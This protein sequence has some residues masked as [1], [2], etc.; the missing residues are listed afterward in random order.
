[1][2]G[3]RLLIACGVVIGLAAC[4]RERPAPEMTPLVGVGGNVYCVSDADELA[5]K[6]KANT[7]PMAT[8]ILIHHYNNCKPDKNR[9][10][11]LLK[12]Q[13]DRGD[14]VMM[15]SLEAFNARIEAGR[16]KTGKAK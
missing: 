5:L 12:M 10:A 16:K 2:L 14:K 4:E 6:S 1:M 7:D 15:E 11:Q 8:W 9:S 3:V 13:M